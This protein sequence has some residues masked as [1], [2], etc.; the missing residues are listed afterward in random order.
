MDETNISFFWTILEKNVKKEI[1]KER[2]RPYVEHY[3]KVF[4]WRKLVYDIQE[5]NCWGLLQL[6]SKAFERAMQE[7]SIKLSN[8]DL[9]F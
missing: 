2:L 6:F 1:K 9:Q 7:M 8:A 3:L 4:V 5:W